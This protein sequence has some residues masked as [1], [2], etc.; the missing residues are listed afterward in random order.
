MSIFDKREKG[1]EGKFA[2]DAELQFKIR[3]KRDKLIGLWAAEKL[4]LSGEKA[5]EYAF[6]IIDE[7]AKLKGDTDVIAKLTQDFAKA[8]I[9]VTEA[10]I[11]AQLVTCE[12]EAKKQL[13]G[14]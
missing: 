9:A 1:S 6:S 11:K 8:K 2:L 5:K 4:G 13:L 14:N 7:D 3:A 10:Q 12:E